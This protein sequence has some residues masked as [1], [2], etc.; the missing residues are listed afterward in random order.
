[1]LVDARGQVESIGALAPRPV[2]RMRRAAGASQVVRRTTM[3]GPNPVDYGWWL[4]SRSAGVVAMI[5][6]SVSVLIGLLM[7]N[8]L[9]RKR[10]AKKR[11]LA[12]HESTALVGLLAITLHGLLL[13]GDSWLKPGIAGIGIPFTMGYRPE[14][15]GLG[16]VAGWGAAA[17]GLSFYV[18]RHIGGGLWRRVHRLTIVVWLLS[19]IHALGAG[20][21]AGQWWLQGIIALTGLPIVFLFILRLLPPEQRAPQPQATARAA[22]AS[23]GGR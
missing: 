11:L 2:V 5:S 10:G 22:G 8:N 20:T 3:N 12:V 4:A 17:L 14:F 19:V 6:I 21:D 16:I 18:R 9:P 15:T 1:M 23:S 13:L 7:A